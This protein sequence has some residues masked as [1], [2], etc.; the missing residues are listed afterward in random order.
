VFAYWIRVGFSPAHGPPRNAISLVQMEC[1]LVH[2]IMLGH[3]INTLY[4]G[5]I[6]AFYLS[7]AV[8]DGERVDIAKMRPI[9]KLGGPF[10]A[11]LGK[12]FDKP[13]L[14]KPPGGE[15]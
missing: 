1:R 13:M 7:D 6:L 10:C 2:V 8:C 9:A 11:G 15:G 5:E 3:G 4:I 14:Q 12:I